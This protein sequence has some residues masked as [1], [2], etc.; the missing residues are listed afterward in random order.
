VKAGEPSRLDP[1]R[2]AQEPPQ[3]QTCDQRRAAASSPGR[4]HS[5]AR[6]EPA[7]WRAAH[8]HAGQAAQRQSERNDHDQLPQLHAQVEA[9]QGAQLERLGEAREEA[10]RVPEGLRGKLLAGGT[11]ERIELAGPVKLTVGDADAVVIEVAG[12]EYKGLGR[13]GQV[14]H[15]EVSGDGLV[16]LGPQARND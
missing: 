2:P 11:I 12:V 16:V 14:V 10:D 8:P 7:G 4:R 13:P 9:R 5:P 15:T 3:P 6:G 1:A